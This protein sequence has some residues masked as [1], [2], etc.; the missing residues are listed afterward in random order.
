L[1]K[2]AEGYKPVVTNTVWGCGLDVS[3]S[4]CPVTGSCEHVKKTSGSEKGV[5]QL[6]DRQ[7]LEK[8][9]RVIL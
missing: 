3:V 5:D 4:K 2:T 8:G 9:S 7:F 1:L 6:N